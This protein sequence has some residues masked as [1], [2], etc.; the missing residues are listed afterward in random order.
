MNLLC[1]LL[2]ELAEAWLFARRR[3]ECIRKGHL[4]N[5]WWCDPPKCERCGNSV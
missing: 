3:I 5:Y 4:P 2:S 1:L